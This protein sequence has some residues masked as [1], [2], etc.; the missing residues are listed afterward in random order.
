MVARFSSMRVYIFAFACACC[1][2]GA[3]PQK[4]PV[5]LQA[6]TTSSRDLCSHTCRHRRF[7][8]VAAGG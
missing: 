3:H 8:T 7:Y 5:S 4:K 6:L 1:V 2:C